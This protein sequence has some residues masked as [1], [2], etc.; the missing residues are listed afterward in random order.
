MQNHLAFPL[1]TAAVVQV[2]TASSCDPRTVVRYFAG[3]P[4]RPLVVTRIKA[5]LAAMNS[6]PG[7]R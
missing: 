2:A 4:C 5:A 7:A 1:T 3:L 6:A